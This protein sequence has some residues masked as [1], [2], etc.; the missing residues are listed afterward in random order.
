[1]TQLPSLRA[2][3]PV[4]AFDVGGTDIKSGLVD[5]TGAV[6][7]LRRTATPLETSDGAGNPER[8]V[9][10]LA[11]LR[12]DYR[13]DFPGVD[14]VAAGLLVPGIVDPDRGI[15]VFSSNLGWRDA[16]IRDLAEQRLGLPVAFAH[17]IHGSSMA[18]YRLG[19]AGRFRDVVVMIIGTGIA[20]TIIIDGRAHL[21]QGYAGE[22]GH[23]PVADGPECA[24]GAVGCLEAVA[25]AGA[26]ARRYSA[27]RPAGS[28]PA[29]GAH[30]V[31]ARAQAG[32]PVAA[33][34]WDSAIDALAL[35]FT[36]I[37]AFL[38][39][40][41]IIIAGGLSRAGDALFGPLR[42]R[43]DRRLSYHRRPEILPAELG[44]DAG[45]AGAALF[46][47]A[48]AGAPTAASGGDPA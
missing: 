18:E 15:G 17:D 43:V 6:L 19:S 33:E 10:R 48:R 24:C 5:P 14:P 28:V 25:S 37:T 8:I 38:A 30:D 47:R 32:D 44:E 20:G 22:F 40:E 1:M 9:A 12:D 26:I 39:P 2:G 4:L 3:A 21:A 29:T 27:L 41:A 23:S 7:G 31:L 13:R 45:L 42:E 46:A 34:V 11:E 36:Q 16:P 35:S